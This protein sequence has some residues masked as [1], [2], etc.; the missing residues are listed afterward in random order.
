MFQEEKSVKDMSSNSGLSVK[1]TAFPSISHSKANKLITALYMV[2]DIMDTGEPLRNKLRTLGLGI[3]SDIYTY[4]GNACAKISEIMSLLD[5]A[6]TLNIIS[7]MNCGI[8]RKEFLLLDQSVKDSDDKAKNL[9]KPLNLLEILGEVNPYPTSPLRKGEVKEGVKLGVQKGNTLLKVLSDKLV[10][11]PKMQDFDV[12]KKKRRREIMDLI[13]K[14]GGDMTITDIR[15][16]VLGLSVQAG[17]LASCGEKTLQRELVSMVKDGVL[18]KT[19][20]KRWSRYSSN[21]PPV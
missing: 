12:L 4:P 17:S 7:E 3:I 19:G 10:H 8:L 9:N 15:T 2:T 14:K 1:D 6:D 16:A 11:N 20:E 5:I 18:K 13:Q 21:T